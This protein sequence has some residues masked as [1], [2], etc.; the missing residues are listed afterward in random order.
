MISRNP[1]WFSSMDGK[2]PEAY[3]ETIR[4]NNQGKRLTNAQLFK[5]FLILRMKGVELENEKPNYANSGDL[6]GF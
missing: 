4:K 3:A 5:E 1:D 2:V 6:N